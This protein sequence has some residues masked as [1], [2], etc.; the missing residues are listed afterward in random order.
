MSRDE[1][2]KMPSI[3]HF[4][5]KNQE[6]HDHF[7]QDLR[8]AIEE[9]TYT[10]VTRVEMEAAGRVDIDKLVDPSLLLIEDDTVPAKVKPS[11][12]TS[13]TKDDAVRLLRRHSRTSL[14]SGVGEIAGS[15]MSIAVSATGT[16]TSS[17]RAC[18]GSASAEKRVQ[19]VSILSP[20][21][22]VIVASA[23]CVQTTNNNTKPV[24]SSTSNKADQKRSRAR[25][26][27]AMHC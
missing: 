26:V 21:P 18:C 12:E 22:D 3:F 10:E 20:E 7:V 8:D 14:D 2:S 9:A 13:T 23:V 6:D 15:Q 24:T 11:K 4:C 19:E 5:A 27:D 16:V 17:R 25:S 1:N